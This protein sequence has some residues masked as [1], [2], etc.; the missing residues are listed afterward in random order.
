MMTF[1]EFKRMR[2]GLWLADKNAVAGMS[3]IDPL[4]ATQ[5]TLKP[6]TQTKSKTP[7]RFKVGHV[8]KPAFL[9]HLRVS[10]ASKPKE[11]QE[12][13]NVSGTNSELVPDTFGWP[14]NR[15]SV[16]RILGFV[17][18]QQSHTE[19]IWEVPTNI[20]LAFAFR[21]WP[22]MKIRN[23]SNRDF[24]TDSF[25]FRFR[26][27]VDGL[28]EKLGTLF[29]NWMRE[30]EEQAICCCYYKH[31][32][33][34][35]SKNRKR[36]DVL[37][38]WY[39]DECLPRLEAAITAALPEVS[40]VTLGTDRDTYPAPDLRF[41]P[42]FHATAHFE[43][44]STLS[45]P[46]YEIARSPV[47][48][49]QFDQFTAATGYVTDCERDGKGSFRF[50]ETIEPIRPKDRGNIPVHNVSFND[51][52]AYCQWA[53]VRLPTEAELLAAALIDERVM[54]QQEWHDFMF[55]QTGRFR[56]EN[57]PNALDGLGEELVTC[58]GQPDKPVIRSGPFYVREVG[59]E[60]R[61]NRD[62][63][64]SN[65]YGLMTGFR[66]CRLT[67]ASESGVAT[68]AFL[69]DNPSAP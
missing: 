3:R 5:T 50:D 22:A 61:S 56:I 51:A 40:S 45:L 55:G 46:P 24:E 52:L 16:E 42:L 48:T 6:S 58:D 41:I 39:C 25:C 49:G 38:G 27:P 67:P 57:Y 11:N 34:D 20:P 30:R 17:D 29:S 7:G 35:H 68:H 37:C 43:N 62:E 21:V 69:P 1:N 14:L 10:F 64:R 63:C 12:G 33:V 2:E 60:T 36:A 31:L 59:W 53:N 23:K 18:V 19:S 4:A 13:T 44:G 66:L 15:S 26:S 9:P 54:D 65:E 28:A 47:T 32:S 8:S